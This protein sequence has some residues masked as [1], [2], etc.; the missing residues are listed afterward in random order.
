MDLKFNK[1]DL[2]TY[3]GEVYEVLQVFKYSDVIV[4]KKRGEHGIVVYTMSWKCGRIH[5]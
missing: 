4:L 3:C 1:G 5:S 2:A